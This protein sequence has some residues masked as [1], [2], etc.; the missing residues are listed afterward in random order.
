MYNLVLKALLALPAGHPLQFGAAEILFTDAHPSA[1]RRAVSWLF[2]KRMN[3]L[4]GSTWNSPAC[5]NGA[6]VPFVP[7]VQTPAAAGRHPSG[8]TPRGQTGA[9]GGK[10]CHAVISKGPYGHRPKGSADGAPAKPSFGFV[11]RG[12]ARDAAGNA[13]RAFP[14]EWTLPRRQAAG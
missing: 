12:G 8:Y 9:N 13:R 10:M 7:T 2:R 4:S 6:T 11:G 1:A 5:I 14:A 3:C